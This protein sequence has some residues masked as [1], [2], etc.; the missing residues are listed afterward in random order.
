MLIPLSM[1]RTVK[2]AVRTSAYMPLCF[3]TAGTILKWTRYSPRSCIFY[4]PTAYNEKRTEFAGLTFYA[5]F[6]IF[7]SVIVLE[8]LVKPPVRKAPA[9]AFRYF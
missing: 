7:S 9:G 4:Q 6:A 1:R 8:K 5:D 3:V 2:P